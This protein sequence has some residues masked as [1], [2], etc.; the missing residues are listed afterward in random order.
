MQGYHKKESGL[1]DPQLTRMAKQQSTNGKRVPPG[2]RGLP[3]LGMGLQMLHDPLGTLQRIFREYGDIVRI[4]IV[5]DSRIFLNHPDYIEQVTV[6]QQSKFHKSKLTKDVTGRLLGEGLLISEG[7]FWRRQRRLAQPAFQRNR[8]NEYAAT[9]VESAETH[10]RKWQD[11]EERDIAHEMMAL[12]L[13]I[14]VRTLFGTTLPGE[15]R[16]VGRSLE[17]LMRYSLR[18][19]RSPFKLPEKWPT[20]A[21]RR[22]EREIQFLDSLVYRI[23]DERKKLGRAGEHN[24]LLSLLMAAMDEDGSQMTAKQLRDEIMTLFT[25]GHETTA[26]TLSWAWYLLSKNPSAEARLYEEIRV[27]LA[28]RLPSIADLGQLPYLR[29]VVNEALR[30]YP[31][32]YILARTSIAPCT[33]GG[34]ELPAGSTV[35]FSQWITHRD[36][37]FFSDPDAFIPERWLDGLEDRLPPGAY[38]PFGDGPRRCIGQN[39]ALMEVVLVLATIAQKFQFRLASGQKIVPDPL[40]TLRPRNGI[41]MRIDARRQ[42]HDVSAH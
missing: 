16:Q 40:V 22:A 5:S 14:A 32:A 39:F 20:P 1:A 30:L 10:S 19:N 17:F 13:D 37:R 7:D 24:D 11:S 36:S 31:P 15:A 3:L 41:R 12:T 23:I 33:I 34:Y 18:R 4:P 21:N 8:I 38:F 9:M 27:V 26:L 25:A 29:G 35:V 6:I 28:G 2:P 42:R